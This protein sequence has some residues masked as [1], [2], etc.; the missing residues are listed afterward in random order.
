MN[1]HQFSFNTI[2]GKVIAF[3]D[4]KG[5]PVLVVNTASQCGFTPQYADL[6][7]L[8]DEYKDRGLVVLGVPSNNFGGQEPGS[9]TEIAQFVDK[10]FKITFPLTEKAE[11]QGKNAHPFYAWANNEAGFLGSPKWNFHKY[12]IGPDG[13]LVDW[14]SS[15]TKPTAEKVRTKIEGLLAPSSG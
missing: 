11:V 6:Q 12:L 8:W 10:E 9:E 3:S 4:F 5:K 14:Y 13:E 7:T 2:D 1:A 15:T